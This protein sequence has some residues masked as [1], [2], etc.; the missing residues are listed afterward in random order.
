MLAVFAVFASRAGGFGVELIQFGLQLLCGGLPLLSL[1]L[2][3]IATAACVGG[4]ILKAFDFSFEVAILLFPQLDTGFEPL[5]QF[6][7]RRSVTIEINFGVGLHSQIHDQ[8]LVKKSVPR[9]PIT[10]DK[11]RVL[12]QTP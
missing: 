6:G 4:S 7:E 5:G 3:V 8:L 12:P 2:P 10:A 11:K 9:V 1:L